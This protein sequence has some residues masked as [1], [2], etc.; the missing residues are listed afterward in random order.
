M[1]TFDGGLREGEL[2]TEVMESSQRI[3]PVGSRKWFRYEF[4][5]AIAKGIYSNN[6]ALEAC[7]C[8]GKERGIKVEHV[9][10]VMSKDQA[11]A[12]LAELEK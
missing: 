12:L 11:D 6:N 2:K 9:V 5:K 4:A 7:A 8:V 10:A 3:I 1:C